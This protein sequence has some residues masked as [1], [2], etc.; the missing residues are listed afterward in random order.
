MTS[1]I[2]IIIIIIITE[3][4]LWI[5]FHAQNDPFML[6]FLIFSV[7]G[8]FPNTFEGEFIMC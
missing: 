2:I 1:I 5:P 7:R 4:R 8:E 3:M 6:S